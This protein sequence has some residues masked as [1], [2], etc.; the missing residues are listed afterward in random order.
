M[1]SP[2]IRNGMAGELE[3]H[4]IPK[5]QGR[6]PYYD[7]RKAR[8]GDTFPHAPK[9]GA[10]PAPSAREDSLP[11][12][13]SSPKVLTKKAE[14]IGKVKEV[15][16]GRRARGREK[17]GAAGGDQVGSDGVQEYD[18]ELDEGGNLVFRE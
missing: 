16:E 9:N 1:S 4:T 2:L 5:S 10:M 17:P 14:R 12:P 15:R 13:A 7:A 18:M 11:A 8:W 3:R 6:Q